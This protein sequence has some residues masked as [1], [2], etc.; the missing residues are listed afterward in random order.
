MARQCRLSLPLNWRFH[1]ERCWP[2]KRAHAGCATLRI[3]NLRLCKPLSS[4]LICVP[5]P[6]AGHGAAGRRL[7]RRSLIR[8]SAPIFNRS[9]RMVEEL[10]L[11]SG[12]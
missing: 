10:A 5:L 4:A 8:T 3:H 2:A 6:S 9:R 1:C 7:M 11:A 12:L